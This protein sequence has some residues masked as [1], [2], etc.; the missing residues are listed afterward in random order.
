MNIKLTEVTNEIFY[1][2]T[3]LLQTLTVPQIFNKFR[4]FSGSGSFITLFINAR[5]WS[6]L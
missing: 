3:V 2:S 1:W 4:A 6:L 5:L